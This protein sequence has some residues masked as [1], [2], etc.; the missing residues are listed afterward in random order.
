[1]LENM[2]PAPG[3]VA[4]EPS[5]R[6]YAPGF[7]ASLMLKDLRLAQAVAGS[8]A[9]PTPLGALTAA[10]YGLHVNA[11]NGGL[12]TSSIIRLLQGKS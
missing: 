12:D 6:D 5:S 11:G 3:P 8:A 2:C 7:A 4:G 10:L 9:A 1:V